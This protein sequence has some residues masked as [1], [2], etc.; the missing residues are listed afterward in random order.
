[1]SLSVELACANFARSLRFYTDVLGFTTQHFAPAERHA[2]LERE[3]VLVT[4]REGGATL[5][6]LEYPF[7]RGL[8]LV[9][10]A[11]DI[12]SVYAGV[13]AY[14]AR[15]HSPMRHVE[16]EEDGGAVGHVEFVVIDPDGYALRFC[17]NLPPDGYG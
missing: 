16:R 12:D 10:W 11:L 17:Q 7:G 8:T 2:V 6:E 5:G 4:L 13:Q 14:G 9:V 15:L 1:M 3:G